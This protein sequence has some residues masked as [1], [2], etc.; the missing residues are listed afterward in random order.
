MFFVCC[1]IA[2][3]LKSTSLSKNITTKVLWAI[4]W[5]DEHIM[6]NELKTVKSLVIVDQTEKILFHHL[7]QLNS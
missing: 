7:I 6:P 2:G 3:V 4:L 1:K 5:I